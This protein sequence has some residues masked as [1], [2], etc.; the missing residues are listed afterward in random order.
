MYKTICII[1]TVLISGIVANS[2]S[3]LMR[4]PAINH[5]G[6]QVAFSFQGDIWTVPSAGGNATRL[7]IH[8]AY[9]SYPIFSPD[10]KQIAFSGARFGN[11][12][13]FVMPAE[14]G[15]AKRLTWHSS[16]DNIAS[17]TEPNQIIFS[18]ARDFRQVERPLEVFAI[19]PAGGTERRILDAVGYDPVLSPDGR[20]MAIV[21]GDINPVFRHE[22]RGSSNRDLWLYDIKNKTYSKLPG[23]ETND[24]LPQWGDNRTLYFLSSNEGAYNLY[25]LAIKEDGKPNGMP[26]K[27]TNFKD[28]AIRHY[29]ISGDGKT[30]V[31]EKEMNLYLLK[32]GQGTNEKMNI[33]IAADDRFDAEEL[34]TLTTGANEYS[35]SPNGKLVAF[36]IR[37]E[38]FIK[39]A[40][41][42]KSRSVNVSNHPYRDMTPAWMND[43][44]L[45]FSSDR[46]DG[47]FDLYMVQSIDTSEVNIF[48]TLKYGLVRIT[49]TP[50]DEMGAIFSSD[51]KRLAYSRG[52]GQLVVS[53]I[54]KTGKL[55]N[56]KILTDGWDT[57]G[58]LAWS[59]DNKWLAYTLSDLYFNQEVFIQP[60]D[61]SSKA[62]NVTMHP[63]SD[64]SPF[65][66][67][68]G[69]KL[70]F[71]SERNNRSNDIWFVW[72][73][74]EDWERSAP[75]W[76]EMEPAAEMSKEK[77]K[78]ATSKTAKVIRIDF[79]NIH[80]R[81]IQVTSFPGD[82]SGMV[83]SKD[84]QTFF[85]TASSST[86]KGRD[87]YSIKWDGKDLKE[88]TKAGTNPGNV[89]M[90]KEGKY[91]YFGKTGGALARLEIK[92]NTTENLPYSAKMKIDYAAERKQVF[93]EAWRT[94]NTG[95][96]DP[97]FHGHNWK[98]LKTKYYERAV[99]A[100]TS[101]D[102]R[103]MFNYMLGE[104]N[105]S[106]MAL[107]AP[108]RAETQKEQT[109]LL[110]AELMPVKDGMK[111]I[112]VIP[113]GPAA[114]QGSNLEEGEI[115]VAVNGTNVSEGENFY[116][117]LNGQASEKVLITIKNNSGKVREIVLRPVVSMAADLYQEWVD[118]RKKLVE[119]WSGGRLGYIHIKSMDIPS[120]EV[121]EREFTA[122]GY[123]KDG[124][125]IDVRYNGGGS[126]ADYLMAVLNYK[127]HAYTIP[128]GASDNLEKDKLNFRDYY[129]V[130]ERLVFAAWTKPSIALCNEGSYSNA[131]IFSHA[132]KTLGIGKLV[133]QPTNG[134][135]ISTGGRTLIDGSFVR[136][137]GRGWFTKT[138][139][140][141]QELG[142]AVPDILVENDI[143]WIARGTDNQLETAAKELIKT[144]PKK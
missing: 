61:N 111:V 109:G 38:V 125:I 41:K 83:I 49:S 58:D 16:A 82:E 87:L 63:R 123:G 112:R 56:E 20:F 14:G 106:H 115:I 10:G 55:S 94:I 4:H 137:P 67:A 36:S 108:D 129:P 37:G 128:R 107:T 121:V 31:Y 120:F 119:K 91:I 133:G 77:E 89:T 34:K 66:S 131:E 99:N 103:D 23:F 134:S 84:G 74:K 57:P 43:S 25:R 26:E 116:S 3:L 40:D 136:L 79:E 144:L 27:L 15:S 130:G 122:A 113:D 98:A 42:E 110:G 93:D 35:V 21:R 127:Q 13:L 75:D 65:W 138:T 46:N 59:P 73:K 105:A 1:S 76:Q 135:V 9:E 19:S 85:F 48:K 132:Y 64:G 7:T 11:N 54:A 24:I 28:E 2:Q 95:F 90:D 6:T 81:V 45:V 12:D 142:A 52:K 72:L 101:N 60:A 126:T 102:F 5:N 8:E 143:D 117:L 44:T 139:D 141:N 33:R 92:T 18:T 53:E 69:S 47:N 50:A 78:T 97:Q 100:S 22:Y 71:I 68:D 114:K 86:A 96:Y 140:Q 80:R 29:C 32:P 17:W 51:G 88:L 39:E 62:V 118:S 104:L 70:G 30:I 124:L